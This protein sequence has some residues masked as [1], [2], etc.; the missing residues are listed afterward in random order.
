VS[1]RPPDFVTARV[2]G[3]QGVAEALQTLRQTGV[4]RD[5]IEV[6]SEIPLPET[7]L[8]GPMRRT[9]LLRFTLTGLVLG[10]A[11]GGFF[12]IGTLFL[13]P[14]LVGG[15]PT[16]VAPPALIIIYE[17]TMFSIVVFTV[18]GYVLESRFGGRGRR[19]YWES[20]S[21]GETYVVVEVPP[22]LVPKRIASALEAH[23][24]RLIEPDEELP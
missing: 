18:G 22:D 17:L 16:Y 21:R 15:Q 8:G 10:L 23:G 5:R 24:A 1:T 20:V 7:L 2:D 14:L 11:V 9:R 12:S 13:Y 19:P 3:E 4:P 6:L